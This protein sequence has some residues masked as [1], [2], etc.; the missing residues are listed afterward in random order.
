MFV[1]MVLAMLY[2]GGTPLKYLL[3]L[4]AAGALAAALV[5]G[6][7][8][9]PARLGWSPEAQARLTRW[10]GLS[11]YQRNRLLVFI[12]PGRDPLG[13]GWNKTQ[14]EIAVGSGGL[15]G[16]GYLQGTQNMLGFLPRTVVPTDFIFSVI[17]EE[18][19]FLGSVTVLGLFFIVIACGL[20]AGLVAPDKTGR[21]LCVGVTTMIFSH[22]M[23]NVAMTIGLM[24]ITGLPLPLISYGGT[25]MLSTM[26]G[27][28]LVQS[29]FIRRA[30]E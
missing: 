17:T 9:L 10:T 1:P 13:A 5:L 14:S 30:G 16:K 22:V 19:G 28:G 26:M 18:T 11:E 25:F 4:L 15:T 3:L 2:A 7:L 21:L 12:E 8:F 27:L 24:P 23:I 29:V 20:Y 6:A